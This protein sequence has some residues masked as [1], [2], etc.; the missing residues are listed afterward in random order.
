MGGA[1]L[2]LAAAAGLIVLAGCATAFEGEKPS[3]LYGQHIDA[4]VAL[5]GHWN[6]QVA[7]EGRRYVLW[8]RRIETTDGDRYCELRLELTSKNL[9]ARRLIRGHPTACELFQTHFVASGD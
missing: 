8:R 4:A 5:Y 9:I 1:P 2:R 3:A 7:L 6:E